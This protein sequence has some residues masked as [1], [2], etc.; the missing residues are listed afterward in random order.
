MCPLSHL[1]H[2]KAHSVEHGGQVRRVYLPTRWVSVGQ[3]SNGQDIFERQHLRFSRND[4]ER[5][6]RGYPPKDNKLE[7]HHMVRQDG[8]FLIL[9]AYL[10]HGNTPI[11]VRE[12]SPFDPNDVRVRTTTVHK[13][14]H[15]CPQ[16]QKRRLAHL[17]QLVINAHLCSFGFRHQAPP[18]AKHDAAFE[19]WKSTIWRGYATYLERLQHGLPVVYALPHSKEDSALTHFL[20]EAYST[21]ED[22]KGTLFHNKDIHALVELIGSTYTVLAPHP[23]QVYHQIV[24]YFIAP[25]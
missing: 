22:F 13:I 7:V 25:S 24:R 15:N 18:P 3:D 9:P 6:K 17:Q 1:K 11:E 10:H 4:L 2:W 16:I 20:Q 23:K 8:S 5:M 12:P 21:F 14:L 19:R